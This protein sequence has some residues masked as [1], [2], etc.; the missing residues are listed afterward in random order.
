[1]VA[2]R[3]AGEGRVSERRFDW[4]AALL[5]LALL[6]TGW[7][8]LA[9][10]GL[11]RTV[12]ETRFYQDLTAR[13]E[14][15]GYLRGRLLGALEKQAETE[16][17]LNTDLGIVRQALEAALSEAWLEEQ[18]NGAA[19]AI[20]AFIRG[21]SPGLAIAVDLRTPLA[22]FEAELLAG[23]RRTAP[24]ALAHLEIDEALVKQ[25]MA[26]LGLPEKLVL[27]DTAAGG[28]DAA[29]L[30]SL[31]QLGRAAAF[32]KIAPA[33]ALALLAL[34]C[35]FKGGLSG[36]LALFGGGAAL[37]GLT[38]L[39]PLFAAREKAI[40]LMKGLC[41]LEPGFSIPG[42]PDP[43]GTAY[44]AAQFIMV[45]LA[46]IYAGAGLALLLC[47]LIFYLLGRF[48]ARRRAAAA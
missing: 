16:P 25:F 28:V 43:F 20:A 33:V 39:A 18:L 4:A 29:V 5:L 37:S 15:T 32:L 21:E 8:C 45:R 47:G 44:E 22:V 38:F 14:L 31:E 11:Q 2:A 23:L 12:L 19:G 30:E 40:L 24:P 13:L 36:G 7:F 6:I 26:R 48:L 34:A 17:L 41:G 46:L 1:M 35:L 27:I 3:R 10:L 9:G 42:L